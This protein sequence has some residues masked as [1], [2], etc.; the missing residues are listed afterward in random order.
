MSEWAFAVLALISFLIWLHMAAARWEFWKADQ[1]LP[2]RRK[3]S[4]DREAWPDVVAV[5]PAR[6]EADVI[7]RT[8]GSVLAQDYPGKL[9]VVLADD[10]SSDGTG[11][12]ASSLNGGAPLDVLK[13]PP[14]TDGWTGKL[15][16]L[17][18]GVAHA[19]R[20]FPSHEFVWL[21]DADIEHGPDTL[22][23]LVSHAMEDN[24]DLVS[25]MVRLHCRRFWER[26]MIP[27]F[28]FF[29]QM[30]YPFKAINAGAPGAFGAAGGCIL[31]RRNLLTR[32]GGF[33]AI[34]GA[35]I[36][37]CT[38]AQKIGEAGGRLWLGLGE[39]SR[40]IRPYAFRDLWNMVARTAYTQL[41][42]SPLLLAGTVAGMAL[43]FLTP[44]LLLL[45]LGL[46]GDVLAA[47]VGAA[48]WVLMS[49]LYAPTLS[50]YGRGVLES[51]LLLPVAVL[52][53]LMTI[54]SAIRHWM[55]RG[56]QWKARHYQAQQSQ[57]S[58]AELS[59]SRAN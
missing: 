59:H 51:L 24:R 12:A 41:H 52:Y 31:V 45:T 43:T 25:L 50:Y 54:D 4:G 26:L 28:V 23:E 47:T 35:L 56:G 49:A 7:K 30:L 48:G 19:E 33:D 44:P 18:H 36:D 53:T 3:A 27:A 39:S 17:K 15:W 2:G 14:L 16:A 6:N 42:Y 57:E 11:A 13:V 58:V 21:T 9:S 20:R 22:A 55:G 38:L 1:K 34:R 29:F 40:S 32:A 37:D 5:I 8:L 10:S 46:H